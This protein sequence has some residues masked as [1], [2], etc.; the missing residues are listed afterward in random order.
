MTE[1]IEL[2]QS[3]IEKRRTFVTPTIIQGLGR[4][5]VNDNER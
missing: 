4:K 1:R 2:L 3:L 5:R